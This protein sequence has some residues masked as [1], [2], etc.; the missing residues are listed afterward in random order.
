LSQEYPREKRKGPQRFA[1]QVEKQ[2]CE[3]TRRGET[4]KKI[5]QRCF[6]CKLRKKGWGLLKRRG[7]GR[8]GTI[9]KEYNDQ[10]VQNPSSLS[11]F[12]LQPIKQ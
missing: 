11:S 10:A 12:P 3:T 7:G 5:A 4:Y 6:T 8:A 9:S 1:K 2:P